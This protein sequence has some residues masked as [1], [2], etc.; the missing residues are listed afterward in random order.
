L[1]AGIYYLCR[2]IWLILPSSYKALRVESD[3]IFLLKRSGSEV[4]GRLAR[5]SLVT[6]ALTILNVF[7]A[8][9]QRNHSVLIFPD[10]MTKE[11]FRELRV[12]LKWDS[13]IV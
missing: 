4:S 1:C 9:K 5:D 13:E 2:D 10:S 12:L 3:N 7:P 6:S 11:S 8:E